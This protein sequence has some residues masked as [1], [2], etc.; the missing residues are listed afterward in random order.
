[1]ARTTIIFGVMLVA[2]G[3]VGY[4]GTAAVSVTALIPAVFGV[5]LAILGWLA[6]SE[7]YRK[8]AVYLA[9]ATGLVAFL[10]TV[11]G[12]IELVGLISG[13]EVNRPAAVVSQSVVAILMAV[14]V[15]LC[16]KSFIDARRVRINK[17]HQ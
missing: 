10:G 3:I 5:V 8:H 13:A 14:F 9:A 12:L 1:V 17:G 6:L 11:R 15:G 2:V 7:R 16:V 4:V